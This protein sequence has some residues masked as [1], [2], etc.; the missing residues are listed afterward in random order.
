MSVFFYAYM[1]S[2]IQEILYRNS[3]SDFTMKKLTAERLSGH[4][5]SNE[6][7]SRSYLLEKHT[8]KPVFGENLIVNA[9]SKRYYV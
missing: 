8:I 2:L 7:L 9:L 1:N 4:F 3:K 5:F 6:K